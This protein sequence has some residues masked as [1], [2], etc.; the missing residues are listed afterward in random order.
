MRQDI[1]LGQQKFHEVKIN[2]EQARESYN[3]ANVAYEKAGQ[4][5]V[6]EWQVNIPSTPAYTK[7]RKHYDTCLNSFRESIWALNKAK[8]T[9][10]SARLAWDKE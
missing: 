10:E 7:A 6:K 4:A 1:P 3:H 8:T 9:Y 5:L 2:L